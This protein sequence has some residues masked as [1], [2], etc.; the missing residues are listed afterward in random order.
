MMEKDKEQ[1]TLFDMTA[2]EQKICACGCRNLAPVGRL[3][4]RGHN[5]RGKG[6]RQLA[7]KEKKPTQKRLNEFNQRERTLLASRLSFPEQDPGEQLGAYKTRR[8]LFFCEY[9]LRHVH[10]QFFGHPV[11]L[12]PWQTEIVSKLFGTLR[13]DGGRQYSK[14]VLH[15]GRK[16]GKS[17]LAAAILL[18]FLAEL[19][20]DD[21]AMEISSAALSKIQSQSTLFKTVRMLIEHSEPLSQLIRI[22]KVSLENR[23]NGATYEPISSDGKLQLGRNLSL[24]IIDEG[25]GL[26]DAELYNSLLYSQSLRKEPLLLSVS[27]AGT[28]RGS[29]YYN[30]IYLRAKEVYK[31]PEKDPTMLPYIFEVPDEADWRDSHNFILANPALSSEKMDGGFRPRDEILRALKDAR[32]TESEWGF[33]TY[34][35][36]QFGLGGARNFVSLEAWDRCCKEID[37]A[38]MGD[39]RV[40]GG[41]DFSSS[42]DLTSIALI[43][44]G[45]KGSR[46]WTVFVFSFLAGLDLMESEKRDRLRYQKFIGT[47]HLFWDGTEVIQI[48]AVID[49]LG[50]LKSHFPKLEIIGYDPYMKSEFSKLDKFFR[51][52]PVPQTFAFM[53]PSLKLLKSKIIDGSFVHDGDLLLR[54]MIENV[55]TVEDSAGNCRADKSRSRSRIDGVSA[56]ATAT[57]IAIQQDFKR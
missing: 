43:V 8:F 28:S 42:T 35:L 37:I 52:D 39:R 14:L 20:F 9:Y 56:L 38:A 49:L 51:L 45:E 7:L 57:V 34:Y 12:M 26:R 10:G 27:T 5:M 15:V 16:N 47:G 1:A 2:Q 6:R 13:P 4:C 54:S 53:S 50:R 30:Q 21:P 44:E 32:E 25:H 19:S 33:R 11:K 29:F 40:V 41:L 55:R 3:Y 23:L 31:S 24:A 18:Y 36:N 46:T 17:F 22:R 48:E